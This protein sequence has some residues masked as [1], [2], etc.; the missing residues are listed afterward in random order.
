MVVDWN[1]KEGIG[2]YGK[3]PT[4]GDFVQRRLSR[5]VVDH[6]TSWFQASL[7]EMQSKP[8]RNNWT[9]RK[10][11]WKF[12]IPPLRSGQ[13]IQLGCIV[14][15]KDRVGRSYPLMAAK[16]IPI[17]TWRYLQFAGVMQWYR[18][19]GNILIEGVE[20]RYSADTLDKALLFK[21]DDSEVTHERPINAD[22]METNVLNWLDIYERFD[23][24]GEKS[25]WWRENSDASD[26]V[27]YVHNGNLSV[28]LFM[29]LFDPAQNLDFISDYL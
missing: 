8:F 22:S 28:N 26:H 11:V 7:M 10:L 23:P 13:V 25:F 17:G 19:L 24:G 21:L 2:W 18:N 27:F 4:V 14:P 5:I 6:W 29:R 20:N 3:I 9:S 1:T 12:L 15:S 16:V